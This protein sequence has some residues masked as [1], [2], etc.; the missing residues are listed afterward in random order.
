MRINTR[1]GRDEIT[2]EIE[3]CGWR[4]LGYMI[5]VENGREYWDDEVF[6][7]PNRDKVLWI[8]WMNGEWFLYREINTIDCSWQQ[9]WVRLSEADV[10]LDT[11]SEGKRVLI[12]NNWRYLRVHFRDRDEMKYYELIDGGDLDEEIRLEE[13]LY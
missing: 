13:A 3:M 2:L 4:F 12:F 5:G 11:S 8:N 7:S 1:K 10:L 9:D 6:V